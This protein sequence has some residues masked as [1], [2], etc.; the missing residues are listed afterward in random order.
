MRASAEEVEMNLP[1][2][3][4]KIYLKIKGLQLKINE[5]PSPICGEGVGELLETNDDDKTK[6][7]QENP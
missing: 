2:V 6:D 1:V 7:L 4:G 3:L 5:F